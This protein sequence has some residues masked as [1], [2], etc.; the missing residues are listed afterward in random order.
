MRHWLGRI[1]ETL[2]DPLVTTVPMHTRDLA[3]RGFHLTEMLLARA[4]RSDTRL[5]THRL[6]RKRRFT[7]PQ[8]G[9]T[10]GE[11]LDNVRGVFEA[12]CPSDIVGRDILL[13]DDVMTTG[14]TADAAARSL[15]EAGAN[16]VFVATIARAPSS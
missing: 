7:P 12:T 10:L 13:I 11:R 6:L 5:V 2:R 4:S 8:A 15:M 9:L 14:A 1:H 3:R 16:T